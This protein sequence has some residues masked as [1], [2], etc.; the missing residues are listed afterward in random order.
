MRYKKDVFTNIKVINTA[1]IP[2]IKFQDK[3][4]EIFFDLSF[5]NEDGIRNMEAVQSN[6]EL[7]P[8][9]KFIFMVMKVFILQRNK[10]DT[11]KGGVSSFVL[12][13]LIQAFLSTFKQNLLQ[14]NQIS[15]L[16]EITLSE[17]L[18]KFL[19]FYANFDY[20]NKA[21]NMQEK[22]V[23]TN[24]ENNQNAFNLFSPIDGRNIGVQAYCL[25]EIMGIFKN[26]FNYIT[27]HSFEEG[28]SILKVLINPSNHDFESFFL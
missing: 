19:Q 2:I 15:K 28:E 10:N 24:I 5:N 17:Y 8:E 14:K 13:C 9:F 7:Y 11:F 3:T 16:N 6:L 18:I 21:I 22:K 12:M 1:R 27:N 23:I 25:K 20:K 26:R 4:S